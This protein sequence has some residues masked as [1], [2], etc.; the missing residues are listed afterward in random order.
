MEPQGLSPF[1]ASSWARTEA[2][3]TV[4]TFERSDSEWLFCVSQVSLP[5]VLALTYQFY[6]ALISLTTHRYGEAFP[7]ALSPSGTVPS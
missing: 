6:E 2:E 1:L 5:S 4:K 3:G 7:Q